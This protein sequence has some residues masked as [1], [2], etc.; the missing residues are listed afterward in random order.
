MI[1]VRQLTDDPVGDPENRGGDGLRA[2]GGDLHSQRS[3]SVTLFA[4]GKNA[5]D[6][7][8]AKHTTKRRRGHVCHE[9]S[10]TPVA[11]TSGK[12]R[13]QTSPSTRSGRSRRRSQRS[14]SVDSANKTSAKKTAQP[15]TI[16]ANQTHSLSGRRAGA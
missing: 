15:P 6:Q 5:S 1:L 14:E 4:R 13:N 8:T 11:R 16:S 7:P 10:Q 12:S 2:A 3:S 9:L